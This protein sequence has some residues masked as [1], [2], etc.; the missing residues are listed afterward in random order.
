MEESSKIGDSIVGFDSDSPFRIIN[1]LFELWNK[2]L[3]SF[4]S[5]DFNELPSSFGDSLSNFFAFVIEQLDD[6]REKFR[7]SL[8]FR[9][10]SAHYCND[11]RYSSTNLKY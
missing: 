8:L 7:D 6:M 10:K 1:R 11:L 5:G 4:L 2:C 3:K 9:E